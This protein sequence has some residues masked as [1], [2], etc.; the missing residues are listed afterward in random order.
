VE[1]LGISADGRPLPSNSAGST[2]LIA[3][4]ADVEKLRT[5]D[6]AL[7]KSWRAELRG[8]LGTLLAGGARVIG[9]DPNGWYVVSSGDAAYPSGT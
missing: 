3:V 9:F 1:A 5:V 2:V 4:P 7:A 8:A 6:L